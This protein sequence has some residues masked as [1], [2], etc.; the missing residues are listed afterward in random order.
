M[1]DISPPFVIQGMKIKSIIESRFCWLRGPQ[2]KQFTLISEIITVKV[3]WQ[4]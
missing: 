3:N 4:G 2:D 1:E